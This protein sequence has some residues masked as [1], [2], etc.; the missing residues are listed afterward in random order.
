MNVWS[1][2]LA[3]SATPSTQCA[4]E[5]DS[6][7]D[8][9]SQRGRAKRTSLRSDS[10][11]NIA[12]VLALAAS[13]SGWFSA[14]RSALWLDE[15]VSYWQISG[16]FSQIWHR[17]GLSFPAYSYILW[18]TDSLFGSNG[19]VLRMPSVLAM[20][21]A[22]YVLYLIAREFFEFDVAVIVTAVFAFS[23]IVAFAAIDARP[24]AFAV[25]AVN[26]ATLMLLR[27]MRANS[28]RHAALFGVAA[29]GIFYFHYLFG[30]I[31]V[32]YALIFLL[33]KWRE[34]RAFAPKLVIAAIPFFLMM[35]PVFSRLVYLF[36]T[37]QSHVFEGV[38]ST[39]ELSR[40]LMPGNI[41]LL[42]AEVAFLA[43]VAR[44]V[45]VP[46]NEPAGAG[47]TSLLL[48]M[49][50]LGVLYGVSVWTPIHVFVERYRLVGLPGVALCWGL[51]VSCLN[52]KFARAL[53][54]VALI[55]SFSNGIHFTLWE[56][57]GY[58]WK[59]ALEAADARALPDHAPLLIC[60][61]FPESNFVPMPA[62]PKTSF[63]FAQLSYYKVKSPVMPLPRA[64][65]ATAESQVKRFLAT[66][67][68]AHQK[69]F[70]VAFGA[71]TKTINWITTTTESSYRMVRVGEYDQVS[72]VEYVPR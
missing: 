20:L 2:S 56:S 33:M 36:Q 60:S 46:S 12:V 53:F 72:V 57:H 26:W 32:A 19:I 39:V 45:A 47:I 4:V 66:A 43:A 17:Q 6:P 71:S 28:I 70:V 44:K 42:F 65:N 21:G 31:L 51:L 37:S 14:I 35:L 22:V 23:P 64:L 62:D 63:L 8:A 27:W 10:L 50:P 1:G 3:M 38:P 34:Y 7:S 25:L 68:P 13:V 18:L 24:Y 52:W 16:G 15:T 5:P 67:I 59:Y 54:A 29:A 61:D 41:A 11:T 55:V 58:T 48:A 40:T 9:G 30:V 49:V 69:F